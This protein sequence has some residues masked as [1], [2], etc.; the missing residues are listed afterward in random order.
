M[1]KTSK[2]RPAPRSKSTHPPRPRDA[3]AIA[4]DALIQVLGTGEM[5][6]TALAQ[7]SDFHLLEPR[8]RG[9]ARAL[10][11]HAIRRKGTLDHVYQQFL[12]H[13]LS[14]HANK[15]RATFLLASCDLLILETPAHAAVDAGV[16]L[17]ATD[18]LTRKYKNVANAV[19]RKVAEFGPALLAEADPL[20]DL[21]EWL[22]TRWLTFYGE[23]TTRAIIAA[24]SKEPSLDFTLKPE[25]DLKDWAERLDAQILPTGSL[26]RAKSTD[27]TQL[28]GFEEGLW[29][30]QDAGAALPVKILAPQPGERIADLCAAPGG[31][32]LQLASLGAEV[33]ALD[34]SKK[35]LERVKQ[36]LARTGLN[37]QIVTADA[38]QWHDDHLFDAILV[39]APCSATGTLRKNP[40]VIWAKSPSDIETLSAVQAR[41]LDQAY[42]LLKPGGRLI[43]CTCSMEPEEGE[44]QITA[45]LNRTPDAKLLPLGIEDYPSLGEAL[46]PSGWLRTRPDHWSEYGG[47]DGF[48]IARL[49]KS[50]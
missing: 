1:T 19:L 16:R 12:D 40:E 46:H 17:M 29:W 20:L 50:V 28:D 48:F 33:I 23:E 27:V 34:R 14:D 11:A 13:P 30:I 6:E 8:D 47:I 24:R 21:P 22:A 35:R 2:H 49:T 18:P 39:D 4:L 45:F 32:T 25:A 41:I 10:C 44:D 37:A 26:R 7:Q 3:R 31:K 9:F 15:T 36:N 5:V 43:Y 38:T 42:T